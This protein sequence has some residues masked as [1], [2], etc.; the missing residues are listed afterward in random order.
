MSGDRTSHVERTK[1]RIARATERMKARAI[2][3]C[4]YLAS[5]HED[6]NVDGCGDGSN[7]GQRL[8]METLRVAVSEGSVERKQHGKDTAK[9]KRQRYRNGG[10]SGEKERGT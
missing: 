7:C 8:A 5:R 10:A 4:Q 3:I 6:R 9:G 1:E 2:G